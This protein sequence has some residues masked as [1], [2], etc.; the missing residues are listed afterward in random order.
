MRLYFVKGWTAS[1]RAVEI[2]EAAGIQF[3]KISVE[4]SPSSL[5]GYRNE[6]SITR[7][8]TLTMYGARYEGLPAIR[9]FVKKEMEDREA[10]EHG[11]DEFSSGDSRTPLTND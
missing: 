8:P 10:V 6:F 9:A 5:S 2:L 4:A 3:D 1:D 7:L 11:V